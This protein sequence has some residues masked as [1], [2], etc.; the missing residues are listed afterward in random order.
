MAVGVPP[1]SRFLMPVGASFGEVLD[2]TLIEGLELLT[3]FFESTSVETVDGAPD[4]RFRDPV[5]DLVGVVGTVS[6]ATPEP[7]PLVSPTSVSRAVGTPS[8]D[9]LRRKPVGDFGG[10]LKPVSI[11]PVPP[12]SS[13]AVKAV[14]YQHLSKLPQ[15]SHYHSP[16]WAATALAMM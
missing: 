7:F 16:H 13:A 1:E 2:T 14:L 4:N 9:N 15:Y 12:T 10:A 6:P 8:A 11:A 3:S 5:G